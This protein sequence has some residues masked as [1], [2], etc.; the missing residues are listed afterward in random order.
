MGQIILDFETRSALDLKTVGLFNYARHE[1]TA[2]WCGAYTLSE[3][4]D[5]LVWTPD[6]PRPAALLDHVAA[7]HPVFAHNAAFELAIW[8][9]VMVPRY[10][11]PVLRPEQTYCTLAMAYAMALPGALEDAAKA[12][13]LDV[14]KD[15]EGRALMLR[16]ARPRKVNE[17]GSII[18]WDEPAKLARLYEYCK[19]DVRVERA[20]HKRLLPL[21]ETERKVWLMDYAIN[22]RG[23]RADL[24]S[25][26][27]G[28][29]L[30]E[31][32]KTH[33]NAELTTLTGGAAQTTTALGP[34]KAWL[35]TQ[36]VTVNSL[37]KEHLTDLLEQ[38]DL[39]EPA[40]KALILR[41]ESSLAST[42]KLEKILELADEDGRLHNMLAYHGANTGRWAARGVQLHNLP[43]E[44]PPT[45]QVER[46]LALVRAGNM[47][48]IDVL[49]GPPMSVLSQCIRGFF[50]P[51]PGHV[52]L[53]G[54]FSNVE[55]RGVAWFS[56]EQW[57]LDAFVAADNG[58]GPGLYELAYAKSFG[59]PVEE[60]IAE[61]KKSSKRQTGK[62][63]ELSFGYQ[64]GV[65]AARRM[66]GRKVRDKS[67]AE[68]DAWKTGWRAVHPNVVS[69][70]YDL[71]RA[72]IGAV[73][74]PGTV[75]PAGAPGRQ[76]R[77]RVA[78][79]F[80][81]CQLPSGR[82]LCYPY[83]KLLEDEYGP[84][85]TYMTVP[86]PDDKKAGR[87]IHDL[88]NSSN[89][90]RVGTYGG[91]LMENV[92][93]ALCRD[94]LVHCMLLLH[95]AGAKIVLHVH[96]EIVAEVEREKAERARA[97]M[98]RVMRAPPRWAAGFPL[99]ADVEI[100]TRYGKG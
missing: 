18:W 79:S 48:A 63:Q 81:W 33:C 21:S 89:W 78:G 52:L 19:Q 29:A 96:D 35:G 65:G 8:N 99:H 83:P 37:D 3:T 43:R 94:L 70:W 74:N 55:G 64:G 80:L 61:G 60:V 34:L 25:A 57:K 71:Q 82:V 9:E 53:A 87:I 86:S 22:Q 90:A 95:E 72:A 4:A 14:Q 100:L 41:Q 1:T 85:L 45:E 54:D 91:S 66:G 46:I 88:G 67:D 30:A 20:L 49:Y 68:L 15:L 58:T 11:W 44:V 28:V 59:V 97:W 92:I 56:G 93:Q 5:P 12:V 73:Q 27:A 7:G 17:D 23:V 42:A 38:D 24:E 16:M 6:A 32:V 51:A 47:R 26:R 98:E 2:V 13:G 76:V 31:Q 75:R 40:R 77:F 84:R 69:T 36:G 10:D 62:V 50:V 39:P